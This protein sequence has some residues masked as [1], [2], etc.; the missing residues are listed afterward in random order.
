MRTTLVAL[1]VLLLVSVSGASASVVIHDGQPGIVA[2]ANGCVLDSFGQS[3]NCTN[4]GPGGWQRDAF[5]DPPI[6]VSD[7]KFWMRGTL[8][9]MN[10][11]AWIWYNGQ[12]TNFGPCPGLSAITEPTLAAMPA[13]PKA[14]PNPA[15]GSCRV[16]F[17]TA[18]VGPVSVQVFDASGRLVRQ[19][20]DG[21]LPIG[22][23]SLPWDGRDDGG[24]D[25]PSGV[26]L[27]KIQTTN[28]TA[29]VKITL[30]R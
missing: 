23:F 14:I 6:P 30:T 28:G 2:D 4:G 29:T 3:W 19:L 20:H 18:A 22:E 12:W 24:Q 8:I 1:A 7:I 16:T 10:D 11:E 25:L 17:Q 9:S 21:P 13:S 5:Y 15:A 26:Y 27:A